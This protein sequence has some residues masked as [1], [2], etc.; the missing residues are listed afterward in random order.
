MRLGEIE[1]VA[2][3]DG[4]GKLPSSYIPKLDWETHKGLLDA[5]GNF[6]IA[7]ACFLIKTRDQNILVDAGLGPVTFPPFRGGDLPKNLADAAV[8]R[9]DI[10]LVLITHLH[11]DHIG[12]LV[13]DGKAYFPNATV[14]F[15]EKDL[16]QFIRRENPDG[17]AQPVVEVL[18]AAGK[19]ET[20]DAD[21]EVATGV[22]TLQTPGHTLGHLSVVAS[23]GTQRAFM[24]GDAI[25]C[26]AQ[27]QDAEWAAMSDIDPELSSRSR[28]ALYR[29]LEGTEDVA[30]ASHFPDLK[31]GRVLQGVGKRYFA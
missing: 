1:V 14:R 2:V 17:F 23:S 10:D 25:A 5:E 22:S 6:D 27:L 13:R 3:N 19:I 8:T 20:I 16:D 15:G 26:P 21:G 7:L 31:F 4:E 29:E 11:V 30:A 28:E 12:W 24:L 9:E 18:D